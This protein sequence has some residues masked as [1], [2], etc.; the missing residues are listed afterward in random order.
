MK[1]YKC[2]VCFGQSSDL[3]ALGN[4]SRMGKVWLNYIYYSSFK[5]RTKN[6]TVYKGVPQKAR[7]T[8]VAALI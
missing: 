3:S 5:V 2:S 1:S 6:P 7:G 8:Q 4:F